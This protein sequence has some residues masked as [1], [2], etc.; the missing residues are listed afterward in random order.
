MR[1][2]RDDVHFDYGEMIMITEMKI[3]RSIRVGKPDWPP[4]E[5]GE[6]MFGWMIPMVSEALA[7]ESEMGDEF[8]ERVFRWC[9]LIRRIDAFVSSFDRVSGAG[10]N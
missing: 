2:G 3:R 7:E 10:E 9:V 1:D 4:P 5:T 6:S 8:V